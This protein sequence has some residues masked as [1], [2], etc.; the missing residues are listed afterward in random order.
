M[1]PDSSVE[2]ESP[3]A[4]EE[5]SAPPLPLEDIKAQPMDIGVGIAGASKAS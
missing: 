1:P 5:G 3:S 4:L 2:A